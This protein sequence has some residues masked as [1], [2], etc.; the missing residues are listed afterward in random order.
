VL[1][2]T[3]TADKEVTD[4]RAMEEAAAKRVAEER[5][6]EEAAVKAAATEDVAGKTTVEAAGAA[7]G[8]PA[9]G[10][11]PS[12]VGAKR[13]VAPSGSTLPTKHPYKGVWKPRF[14][15]LSLLFSVGLHSLITLFA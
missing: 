1:D 11:V 9:P 4:K 12:A 15:Q 5:A 10:Q 13:V 8:S 2:E 6:T 3:T 7:G 14:V